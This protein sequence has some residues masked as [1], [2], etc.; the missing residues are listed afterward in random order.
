MYASSAQRPANGHG[1]GQSSP[2][3][4][5]PANG[6]GWHSNSRPTTMPPADGRGWGRP[7]GR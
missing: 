4:P 7:N 5:P 2:Y 3:S 6:N 1:W